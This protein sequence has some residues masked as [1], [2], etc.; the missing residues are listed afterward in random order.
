MRLEHATFPFCLLKADLNNKK[1]TED[2][3]FHRKTSILSYLTFL[4]VQDTKNQLIRLVSF[5]SHIL[6]I[7]EKSKTEILKKVEF[8]F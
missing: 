6:K 3:G 8:I 4:T 7:S 2:I 5:I 1:L